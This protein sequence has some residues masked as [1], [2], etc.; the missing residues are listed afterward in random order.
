MLKQIKTE[1][2]EQ[3][4]TTFI[5]SDYDVKRKHAKMQ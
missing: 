1:E 5:G 4:N 2:L 3:T